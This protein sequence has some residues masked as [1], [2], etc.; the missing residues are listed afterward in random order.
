MTAAIQDLNISKLGTDELPPPALL[1]L[2]IE[3]N[4]I[5]FGSTAVGTNAAGNAVPASDPT[6]LFV[7]GRCERQVNNLSTNIPYGAA[8]AQQVLIRPGAYYYNQDGSISAA[9]VG[10]ACFFVDDNTV[11][12]NAGGTSAVRPFAGIIQPPGQGQ[13]GIFLATNTQVPV[14]V[15]FPSC[16]GIEL[17][18]TVALPLATLQTFTSGTA[19]NVGFPLPANARLNAAEINVTTPLSGG[20]ASAV[21]MTLQ[22]GSDAAGSIIASTSVFTGA[23]PVIATPGSNP[24][25]ARG[26]QQ[27]KSTITVTAGTMA[28]LTAGVLSVD[29]FYTIVP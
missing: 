24:Y 12:L 5:I 28:G 17:R 8:G 27:I 29:L 4:K 18:Y 13:A 23:N 15:G 10:Q 2:P 16:T 14:Y 9:N 19:F 6:C 3:A 7:W 20:G 1:A 26:A 22:G 21:T 25:T 11:S